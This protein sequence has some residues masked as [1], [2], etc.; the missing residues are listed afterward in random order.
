[1]PLADVAH[2]MER[3]NIYDGKLRKKAGSLCLIG[4]VQTR[5]V[6]TYLHLVGDN[7][8][9][10]QDRAYL[11]RPACVKVAQ[12]NAAYLAHGA[13]LEKVLQRGE[14]ASV[15]IVLPKQLGRSEM[16]Q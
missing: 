6:C 12:P 2:A 1:M 11:V 3:P 16:D 13:E 14:V 8:P 9:W 15:L 10:A 5:V 7:G 4:M